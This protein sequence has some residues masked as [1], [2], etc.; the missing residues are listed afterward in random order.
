MINALTAKFWAGKGALT[1]DALSSCL[2]L[3]LSHHSYR[4]A[5]HKPVDFSFLFSMPGS[6]TK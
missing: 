2:L 3:T 4:L 1:K 6:D 5:K